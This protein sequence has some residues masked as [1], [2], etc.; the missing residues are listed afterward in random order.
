M[1]GV[2]PGQIVTAIM[3][4]M[5]ALGPLHAQQQDQ[6]PPQTGA[7]PA[8]APPQKQGQPQA[9][10]PQNDDRYDAFHAEQDIEVGTFYMHKGDI[11]AAIPRFEDAAKLRPKYGK[12]RLLLA[13]AYEKK[14]DTAMALKYYKEYL[15][16]YP[17]SPDAKKIQKKIEKLEA[18]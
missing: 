8:S 10:P 2:R 1:R 18:Q 4:A 11:D 6:K 5:L 13:E 15:S 14:R 16:V 3:L 12:P 17:N 9:P 7:P